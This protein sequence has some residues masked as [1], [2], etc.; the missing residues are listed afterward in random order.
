M[1]LPEALPVVT[2]S[3]EPMVATVVLLLLHVPPDGELLSA[4]VD[5]WQTVVV[6][7][8]EPEEELTVTTKAAAVPQPLL[9]EIVVVPVPKPV[10][11]PAAVIVA[12][13]VFELVQ[14]PPLLLL[15]N[16]IVEL[17]QATVEPEMAAGAAFTVMVRVAAVPQPVE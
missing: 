7:V 1:V 14:V 4:V 17:R 10:T 8:I 6:P 15:L 3:A 12:T 5:P 11:I 2:P 9:Y 13:P 16:V